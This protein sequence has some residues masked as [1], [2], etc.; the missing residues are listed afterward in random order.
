MNETPLLNIPLQPVKTREQEHQLQIWD[1]FRKKY[2]ILTPEEWVR[3]QLLLYL[4]LQLGY[5]I[6][7][8]HV[9][10][11]IRIHSL[12]RRCDAIVYNQY[13]KPQMIVECKAP[14]IHITDDTIM[15]IAHYN[16][17]LQVP[18]LLI[19]NGLS[20]Y[21]LFRHSHTSPFTTHDTLPNYNWLLSNTRAF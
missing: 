6:G 1:S 4:V 13:L 14:H 21:F 7:R 9:E 5:P 17:S 16:R 12:V 20:H 3:Q 10:A 19:S 11:T 18:C 8:I 2:V 15:Q